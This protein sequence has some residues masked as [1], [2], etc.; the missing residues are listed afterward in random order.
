MMGSYVSG[1]V[2][3][4]MNSFVNGRPSWDQRTLTTYPAG[5][6]SAYENWLSQNRTIEG[7][8]DFLKQSGGG[9]PNY[10]PPPGYFNPSQTALQQGNYTSPNFTLA[11]QQ[12]KPEPPP[13]TAPPPPSIPDPWNPRP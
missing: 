10:N 11:R 2:G 13:Y 1:Y 3:P 5:Q 9:T 8:D 12:G 6:L 4:T 7:W